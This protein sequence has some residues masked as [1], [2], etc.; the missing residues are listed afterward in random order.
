MKNEIRGNNTVN[1]F[2]EIQKG[3]ELKVNPK[4]KVCKNCGRT[5]L[6]KDSKCLK[7]KEK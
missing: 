5:T 4:Q 2:E 1:D 7:C 6:S 3:G